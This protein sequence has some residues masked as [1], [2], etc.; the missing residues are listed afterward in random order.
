MGERNIHIMRMPIFGERN[1]HNLGER[2]GDKYCQLEW[3]LVIF[4][5]NT[6]HIGNTYHIHVY[7]PILSYTIFIFILLF[8]GIGEKERNTVIKKYVTLHSFLV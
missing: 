5:S 1:I 7:I 8:F 2:N 3:D 4:L 6:L